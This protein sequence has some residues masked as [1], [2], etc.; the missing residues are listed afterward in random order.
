MSNHK[1]PVTGAITEATFAGVSVPLVSGFTLPAP[2]SGPQQN[3]L[4]ALKQRASRPNTFTLD[5]PF[6]TISYM[7]KDGMVKRSYSLAQWASVWTDYQGRQAEDALGRVFAGSNALPNEVG[8]AILNAL[9]TP[10]IRVNY[11]RALLLRTPM[12]LLLERITQ[13]AGGFRLNFNDP[14]PRAIRTLLEDLMLYYKGRAVHSAVKSSVYNLCGALFRR[15]PFGAKHT[16]RQ[17][18]QLARTGTLS[19]QRPKWL[20]KENFHA[21][22]DRLVALESW[23]HGHPSDID[24]KALAEGLESTIFSDCT[25]GRTG[26]ISDMAWMVM[27]ITDFELSVHEVLLEGK[28]YTL[29]AEADDEVAIAD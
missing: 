21:I 17:H 22:C 25:G 11:A 29:E 4:E 15:Y 7:G 5:E 2:M 27:P 26:H 24:G 10:G 19:L 12:P 13:E 9:L 8:K 14:N 20:S 28:D 1:K 16:W 3:P 23:R 6:L 18:I